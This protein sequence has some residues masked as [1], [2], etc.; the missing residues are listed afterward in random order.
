M[1]SPGAIETPLM[2][3]VTFRAYTLDSAPDPTVD[4]PDAQICHHT[5]CQLLL[6][7]AGWGETTDGRTNSLEGHDDGEDDKQQW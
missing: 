7:Q 4:L 3:S 2:L 5:Y 1:I 6:L